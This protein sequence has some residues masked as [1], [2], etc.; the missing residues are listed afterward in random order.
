MM[1]TE[2]L[3]VNVVHISFV[4]FFCLAVR[5]NRGSGVSSIIKGRLLPSSSSS[6]SMAELTGA[7]KELSDL[8]GRPIGFFIDADVGCESA[9]AADD[10]CCVEGASA[11][12]GSLGR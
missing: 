7:S 2:R 6:D 9:G 3:T 1:R 5:R 8:F 11:Q 4:F 12:V 10:A